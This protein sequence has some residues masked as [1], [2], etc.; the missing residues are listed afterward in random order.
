MAVHK[1]VASYV[2]PAYRRQAAA[3][4]CYTRKT[5]TFLPEWDLV[6]TPFFKNEYD[7][8]D[9]YFEITDEVKKDRELFRKYAEHLLQ[10]LLS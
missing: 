3:A 4:D 9:L 5:G 10:F 1:S 7:S 2:D 6:A 8:S